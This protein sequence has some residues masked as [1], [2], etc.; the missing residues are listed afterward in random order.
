EALGLGHAVAQAAPLVGDRPFAVLLGDDLVDHR[1]PL[2]QRMIAAADRT[3]GSVI[4]AMEVGDREIAMYGC[5]GPGE[6]DGELVRVATIVEKPAPEDAPSRLAVIGRYVFTPAIFD[7]LARTAP[8]KGGEIQ[9]TDAIAILA[10]EQR[11]DALPFTDGRFDV[12]NPLDAMQAQVELALAR[13]D[14]GPP[15]RDRLRRLLDGV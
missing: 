12:G 6:T 3:G 8:G 13:D 7:A 11:V 9:L 2:L 1:T 14:I 5:V 15:L 10:G 4:A